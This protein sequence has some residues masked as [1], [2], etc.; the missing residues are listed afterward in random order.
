MITKEI[1]P[2]VLVVE[3]ERSL[4]EAIEIKLSKNGF[5]V[6]KAR[7]AAEAYALLKSS[8]TVD[9]VW[10]DHYLLGTG[11]GLDIV[12]KLKNDKKY[13]TTPIFIVSNTAG[14]DK[15][16]SYINLGVSKY[17]IKS[18]NRLDTI[19]QDIQGSLKK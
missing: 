13:K 17:Y 7:T 18:N 19:I 15:I 9:A 11:D 14:T 1:K 5:N 10:L 8:N 12:A 4:L 3:D 2:T 16:T 6:L